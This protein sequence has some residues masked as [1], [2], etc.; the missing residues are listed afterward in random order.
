MARLISR[1]EP[2]CELAYCTGCGCRSEFNSLDLRRWGWWIFEKFYC[3]CP[4]CSTRVFIEDFKIPVRVQKA[5]SKGHLFK[6]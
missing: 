2:W 6:K 5:A 4:Q 1:P 3:V